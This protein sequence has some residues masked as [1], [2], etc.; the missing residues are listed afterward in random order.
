MERPRPARRPAP[1]RVFQRRY[2]HCRRLLPQPC[3]Y[4]WQGL[5]LGRQRLWAVGN[6]STTDQLT[7]VQIDPAD[8][9]NI[10]EVAAGDDSSYALS[11]DGSLWVWGVGSASAW[12]TG[13]STLRPP[14]SCHP[15]G[16][17]SRRSAPGRRSSLR[18]PYLSPA[19]LA[20]DANGDGKVD[21]NDLTVVLTSF[22]QSGM[23]WSQGDFNGDGQVDVN[24][25]TILLTAFGQTSSSAAAAAV[26]EPC[27][28]ALAGVGISL[29]VC[30]AGRRKP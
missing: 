12:A 20:G 23:S 26:P 14:T 7:P 22:G 11:A 16:T 5:G 3:R 6:G 17:A 4:E 1:E 25:L 19:R 9:T 18:R 2:G 13:T 28:L 29:L 27:S 30:A 21:V 8:L 24:D 15:A 10:T